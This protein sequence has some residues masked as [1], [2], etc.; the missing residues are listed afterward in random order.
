MNQ[1]L[2][3]KK[4]YL[5]IRHLADIA[6]Q[7]RQKELE[8]I[9]RKNM[10]L[11]VIHRFLR[12]F[13]SIKRMQY[14]KDVIS[15]RKYRRLSFTAAMNMAQV[16]SM[17]D[18]EYKIPG[19]RQRD[20]QFMYALAQ[21]HILCDGCRFKTFDC[22]MLNAVIRHPLSY[23]EDLTLF[24]VDGR[25]QA[26]EDGL[27]SAIP[28]SKSL[29]SL[30]ILGGIYTRAFFVYLLDMVQRHNP[31]IKHLI[32]ENVTRWKQPSERQ[33]RSSGSQSS[34]SPG[35]GSS[36]EDVTPMT[37]SRN[38][39]VVSTLST[40]SA[41]PPLKID[42]SPM[43]ILQ[44]FDANRNVSVSFDEASSFTQQVR[45][46]QS[47]R[48]DMDSVV[49]ALA[50]SGGK[51]LCDFFNF[52]MPG[53]EILSLHGC[54]LQC[55]DLKLISSGKFCVLECTGRLSIPCACI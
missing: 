31:R 26:F 55:R 35:M 50:E 10:A 8:I 48:V 14:V 17:R 22:V 28:A 9:R 15:E 47:Q 4:I 49:E 23:L 16:R 37:R 27:I 20:P 33:I 42:G 46:R 38:E 43:E 21:T 19:V 3:R 52:T 41:F 2:R 11:K 29:K 24:N 54:D 6:E 7:I 32:I 30:S 5:H 12:R 40:S 53:I 13:L 45:A 1:Y 36:T 34:Q 39:S 51:L 44:K 25:D 18:S